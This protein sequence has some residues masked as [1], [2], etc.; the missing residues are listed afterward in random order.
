MV[1]ADVVDATE[2]QRVA[3]ELGYSETVF[4]EMPTADSTSAQATIY[5][6]LIELPFAGHPTVGASWWLRER[7]LPVNTLQVPAGLVQ[8]SY[9]D[10]RTAIEAPAE[11]APDFAIHDLESPDAVVSADPAD[12][13][14]DVAHYLWAWADRSAG[15]VR[16]RMFAANLGVAEDQ[17][18]G[19]AAMRLTDYLSRDLVITQGNG[20]VIETRWSP[21]TWVRIAGRVTEDTV[22]QID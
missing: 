16:A 19:S 17:A 4:V 2:R 21:R 5:T 14:D 3:T 13:S 20:S 15:A 22:R 7:G 12:Y 1:D 11:W 8:V 9:E 10:D 18:T 6:P